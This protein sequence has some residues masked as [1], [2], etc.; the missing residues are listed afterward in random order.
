MKKKLFAL[1]LLFSVTILQAQ[2]NDKV[3]QF[4]MGSS[5][6]V[7]IS[8]FKNYYNTGFGGELEVSYSFNEKFSWYVKTGYNMFSGKKETYSFSGFNF[9]YTAPRISYIPIIGG[10]RYTVGNFSVGCAAGVGIYNFKNKGNA[11]NVISDTTGVSFTY[12]PEIA[13]KIGNLKIAASYTSSILKLDDQ[14]ANYVD[15]K[16]ATFLGIKLF[17]DF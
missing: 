12:S 10:P 1:L 16:N 9:D 15:L 7:P 3:W 17:Y 8:K 13:Y 5:V 4:A 6:S 2:E 11:F 14:Y